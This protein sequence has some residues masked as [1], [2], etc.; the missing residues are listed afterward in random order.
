MV[1]CMIIFCLHYVELKYLQSFGLKHWAV[2]IH[3]LHANEV[4]DLPMIGCLATP[5]SL[6]CTPLLTRC[7]QPVRLNFFL[8]C[9]VKPIIPHRCYLFNLIE[10]TSEL[11]G[12]VELLL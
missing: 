10:V 9:F 8:T 1:N 5:P 3:V 2:S 11:T 7:V 12:Y 6:M 4:T